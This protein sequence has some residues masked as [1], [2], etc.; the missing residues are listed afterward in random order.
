MNT[1]TGRQVFGKAKIRS[2]L[3]TAFVLTLSLVSHSLPASSST[4]LVR[5]GA[6]KVTI[7]GTN[8][9]GVKNSTRARI[10]PSNLRKRQFNEA[11][12]KGALRRGVGNDL[13]AAFTKTLGGLEKAERTLLAG[14]TR[15]AEHPEKPHL[16]AAS[17]YNT[18]D[19][20]NA[21]LMM[22]NQGPD[23][24][25]ARPTIFNSA[26]ARFDITPVTL[27]GQ[28]FQEVNLND[29]VATAGESFRQGSVQVFY[30]GMSLELGGVVQMVNAERGLIFDEELVEPARAFS[31]SRLEGVWW[32]PSRKHDAHLVVSNTTDT[33]LSATINMS[34]T[35]PKRQETVALSLAPHE[36]RIIDMRQDLASKYGRALPHVG[37]ISIEHSG[38]PG[39]L[40][41]RALIG[42]SATGYSSV[43][44]LYDPGRAKTKKLHGSGLRLGR[45][46]GERLTPVVVAR[47]VGNSDTIVT[48]RM[49][50][51]AN[52]GSRSEVVLH[53]IYLAPGEAKTVEL[54][55]AVDASGVGKNVA[56]AGLE[57]EYTS[58]PGSVVMSALSMS[59]KGNHVFRV[60]LIDPSTQKSS[61]AGYP[62]IL[63]GT[64]STVA[65]IK[66]VTDQPRKYTL[67]INFPGGLWATGLKTIE[68]HETLA[69]DVRALRDSQAPDQYERT[70]PPDVTTGHIHWSVDKPGNIPLIGRAEQFDIAKGVSSTSACFYCCQD[71]FS[72]GEC[73]PSEI[74]GWP[75][76][77]TQ[78][79]AL[80]TN[81]D[82]YYNLY[83]PFETFAAFRG[84]SSVAS[85][86][87]GGYA[88]A[89]TEGTTSFQTDFSG[90]EY[91]PHPYDEYCWDRYIYYT[92]S[93]SCNVLQNTPYR[94]KIAA[95]GSNPRV[96]KSRPW[97]RTQEQGP[98][99]KQDG[100]N[101]L[102]EVWDSL[103][104]REKEQRR[105]A[106]TECS[107]WIFTLPPE[108]HPPVGGNAKKCQDPGRRDPDARIDI[109]IFAGYA[110]T[111]RQ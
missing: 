32:L 91:T 3:I 55:E 94:G 89:H 106:Y 62:L 103:T 92:V 48:G 77:T 18:S 23:P 90:Y 27:E 22:L 4:G 104:S 2:K 40:V 87:E 8:T 54:A 39:A 68:A 51:T 46:K 82:C 5:A 36:T 11:Q 88:T 84:G 98:P 25:E 79:Y 64:S 26:G 34:G 47:N 65:Y 38:P 6:P 101:L 50:Y 1:T 86:T 53:E 21:T 80:Q 109:D 37:G 95:Q 70:I 59:R 35:E 111:T 16:L 67:Q 17:Y 71:S 42:D 83:D 13:S 97:A 24:L 73:S 52:D 108:G 78:V 66:N 60:P 31:S 100:I 56:A 81:R 74:F 69:F 85:I 41:G 63:N 10:V 58:E 30:H 29:V 45:I 15:G 57:F 102:N 44:E 28:S 20:L 96:E 19:N 49:P 7:S 110:F 43:V 72:H 76:D 14:V 61:A 105:R 9:E 75:G 33:S 12:S 93:A 107:E 99:T